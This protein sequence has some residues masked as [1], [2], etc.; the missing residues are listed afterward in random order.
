M[1]RNLD[2]PVGW[3]PNGEPVFERQRTLLIPDREA[4]GKVA[5]FL[6]TMSVDLYAYGARHRFSTWDRVRTLIDW[7]AEDRNVQPAESAA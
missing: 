4:V 1:E 7:G 6:P 5:M 3:K 2:K